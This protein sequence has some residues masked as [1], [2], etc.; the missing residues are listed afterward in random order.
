MWAD[1]L[2]GGRRR[3]KRA[4]ADCRGSGQR[5]VAA[6]AGPDVRQQAAATRRRRGGLRAAA[7]GLT[8]LRCEEVAM[9][10]LYHDT[11]SM[12]KCRYNF[13][14]V[15][16]SETMMQVGLDLPYLEGSQTSSAGHRTP[17]R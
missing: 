10:R 2:A 14:Y 12:K 13:D 15:S 3:W 1:E 5:M 17:T 4:A 16:R 11:R 9:P 7:W 6:A 8:S